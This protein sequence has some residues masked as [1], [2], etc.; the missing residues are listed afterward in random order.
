[1]AEVANTVTMD[2]TR[3]EALTIWHEVLE[4]RGECPAA[5]DLLWDAGLLSGDP[6]TF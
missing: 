5:V 2:L 1:M 6:R 4:A 3:E